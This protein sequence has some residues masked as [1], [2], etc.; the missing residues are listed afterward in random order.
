[1]TDLQALLEITPELFDK[2]AWLKDYYEN[3]WML[4]DILF[5]EDKSTKKRKELLE[6]QYDGWSKQLKAL[7]A[8]AQDP[9]RVFLEEA[10]RL[11]DE[12]WEGLFHCYANPRIP[13]TNNGSEQLINQLKSAE[14]VLAKT[15]NPGARFI[16]NAPINAIFVNL[17]HL[18]DE[19]FIASRTREEMDH[20][21]DVL[22]GV[23][24]RVGVARMARSN[25]RK[26]MEEVKKRWA[27]DPISPELRTIMSS[28]STPAS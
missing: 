28:T 1:M 23:R 12:Q 5:G 22:K 2:Q 17:P 3:I 10:I 14:R 6:D 27:V 7:V 11:T 8:D 16:N 19:R 13:A 9:R 21:R 15:P 20:A 25:P 24:H 18:P 4:G 26:L